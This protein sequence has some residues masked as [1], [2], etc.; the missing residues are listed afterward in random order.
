MAQRKTRQEGED[1]VVCVAKDRCA[2]LVVL[3]ESR[4]RHIAKRHPE[5]DGCHMA[6]Q[7]AI[8]GA[9]ERLPGRGAAD[10]GELVEKLFGHNLGPAEWLVVVVAYEGNTGRVLTAYG[11][12][13]GPKE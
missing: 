4:M 11:S 3:T 7:T 2:R 13:K 8:E 1:E 5:L 6:I 12:K 9:T 10:D